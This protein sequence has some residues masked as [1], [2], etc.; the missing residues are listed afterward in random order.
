MTSGVLL[1]CPSG[2]SSYS[3]PPPLRGPLYPY[4]DFSPPHLMPLLY[5]RLDKQQDFRS[6]V[7]RSSWEHCFLSGEIPVKGVCRL[8]F[9]VYLSRT[10]NSSIKRPKNFR[11]IIVFHF[12]QSQQSKNINNRFRGDR[13]YL[14]CNTKTRLYG[15]G[16]RLSDSL[17]VFETIIILNKI[18][19]L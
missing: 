12:T 6:F 7:S 4:I 2:S 9:S 8:F 14:L 17:C 3:N 13:P 10:L 19:V 11:S 1:T 5:R 15:E 16:V 18:C